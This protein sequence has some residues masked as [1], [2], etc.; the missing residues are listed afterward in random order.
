MRWEGEEEVEVWVTRTPCITGEPGLLGE[1]SSFSGNGQVGHDKCRAW[2]P[3]WAYAWWLKAGVPN[4]HG[5]LHF[6]RGSML[7]LNRWGRVRGRCRAYG[8]RKGTLHV[9]RLTPIAANLSLSYHRSP[10]KKVL[11]RAVS[12][13]WLS[14]ARIWNSVAYKAMD[15]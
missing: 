15:W 10:V 3:F 6:N 9:G 8:Y 12:F 14:T 1:V 5:F 7:T 2:S 13:N 11:C 4:L